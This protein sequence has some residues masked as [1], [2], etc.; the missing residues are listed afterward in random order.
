MAVTDG[1]RPRLTCPL[2]YY[3]PERST[4]LF[5]PFDANSKLRRTMLQCVLA[6]I[7]DRVAQIQLVDDT[8]ANSSIQPVQGVLYPTI[9]TNVNRETHVQRSAVCSVVDRKLCAC[10]LRWP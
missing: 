10:L 3:Q 9:L 4:M 2:E 7:Q 1:M 6:V 5:F 8:I